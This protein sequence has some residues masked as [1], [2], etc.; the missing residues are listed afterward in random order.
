MSN[1]HKRKV[2]NRLKTLNKTDKTFKALNRE[3]L[4]TSSRTVEN[5]SPGKLE[6]IKL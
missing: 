3:M 6:I 5:D 1:M 2:I 4:T